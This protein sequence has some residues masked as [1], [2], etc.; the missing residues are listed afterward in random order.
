[1]TDVFD[2]PDDDLVVY[3]LGEWSLDQRTMLGETLAN[4]AI[5]HG[6]E[7]IDLV[8]HADFEPQVDEICDAIERGENVADDAGDEPKEV[9]GDLFEAA[10]RLLHDATDAGAGS[11]L[12][13]LSEELDPDVPPFGVDP[14][15]WE[16]VVDAADDL[17]DGL[18]DDDEDAV[19]T[20]ASTLRGLLRPLV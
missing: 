16:R 10:D 4:R 2:H 8:V 9:M 14:A 15:V 13:Q 5:P 18:A 7:G 12:L 6:W 17:A 20:A 3:E 1:M 19:A 11:S